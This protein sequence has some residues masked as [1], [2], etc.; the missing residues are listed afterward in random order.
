MHPHT[1]V[2]EHTRILAHV[3]NYL[4]MRDAPPYTQVKQTDSTPCNN[5]IPKFPI[6]GPTNQLNTTQLRR[7]QYMVTLRNSRI[8]AH[9]VRN[10]TGRL[11]RHTTTAHTKHTH[12]HHNGTQ[13][14][15]SKQTNPHNETVQLATNDQETTQTTRPLIKPDIPTHIKVTS[16]RYNIGA[17]Q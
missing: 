3:P 11:T 16:N 7:K 1:Q 2:L 4:D 14:P 8:L 12:K 10:T 15:R 13:L 5:E 17:S 9:S 6:T